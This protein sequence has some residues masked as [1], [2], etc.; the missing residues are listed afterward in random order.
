MYVPVASL[1]DD[2]GQQ[3]HHHD[4]SFEMANLASLVSDEALLGYHRL[5][6]ALDQTQIEMI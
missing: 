5:P 3:Q 2:G 4:E 1:T 6:L